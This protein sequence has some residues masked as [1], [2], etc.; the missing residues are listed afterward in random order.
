MEEEV[1]RVKRVVK[2]KEVEREALYS[3]CE[4]IASDLER[5]SMVIIDFKGMDRAIS[6]DISVIFG[7]VLK[8]SNY[9]RIKNKY[10]YRNATP[11]IRSLI[12]S[13]LEKRS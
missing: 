13:T 11:K 10:G 5:G 3:I 4:D 8:R 6:E 9:D 7:E 2:L 12:K 1:G